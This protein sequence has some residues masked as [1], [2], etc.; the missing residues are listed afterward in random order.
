MAESMASNKDVVNT[1]TSFIFDENF[2]TTLSFASWLERIEEIVSILSNDHDMKVLLNAIADGNAGSLFLAS[3]F[4]LTNLLR[5]ILEHVTGLN[6]NQRNK[7]DHT[8][9]YL[10]AVF[11]HSA[12]LSMLVDHETDVNIQCGKYGSPLHAACFAEQLEA[13]KTLLKLDAPISCGD[14]FDD[15]FQAACRSG[16]E[17]VKLFLID[18]DSIVKSE[19]DY[20]KVLEGAARAGFVGV[21]EKLHEPQFLSF[22]N[23][24]PDKVK[25]KTQKAIQGGQLDVIRQFLDKQN[26]R[27]AVL[28]QDAVAL[29]TLYNHKILMKFLLD[30]GMSVEAEGSFDTPLRTACLLNYQP[31]ARLVLHRET[32]IDA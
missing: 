31:I 32:K 29:A 21:V 15:A 23:S 24:K 27:R 2:D 8:P 7:H 5:V 19:N 4:E 20:E 6:V 28:P 22:N 25:K 14:V 3:V 9:T 12:S 11:G 16:R 13:V 17:G 1:L 26:E 30:E 10:A 18:S